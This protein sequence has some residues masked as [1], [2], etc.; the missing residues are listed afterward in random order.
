MPSAKL[1]NFFYW[2]RNFCMAHIILRLDKNQILFNGAQEIGVSLNGPLCHQ[3]DFHSQDNF[4]K[5]IEINHLEPN[6]LIKLHQNIQIAVVFLFASGIR[7][8]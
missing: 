6:G 3:I 2:N 1:A 7:T 5:F 8:E 4:Q